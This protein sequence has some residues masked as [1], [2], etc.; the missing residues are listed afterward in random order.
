MIFKNSGLGGSSR[1]L[2]GDSLVSHVEDTHEDTS[3]FLPRGCSDQCVVCVVVG[4]LDAAH[5]GN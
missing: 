5:R 3:G 1:V 2:A 4:G